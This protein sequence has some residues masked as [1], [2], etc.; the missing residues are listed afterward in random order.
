MNYSLAKRQSSNAVTAKY[1][2]SYRHPIITSVNNTS[3]KY[4]I[5]SKG[6]TG[7][8]LVNGLWDYDVVHKKE[9]KCTK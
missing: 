9:R 1:S 2:G 8:Q 3:Y 5:E 4:R 6:N 7:A